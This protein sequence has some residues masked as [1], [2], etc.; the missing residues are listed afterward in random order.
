V[1]A[2]YSHVIEIENSLATALCKYFEQD[3]PANLRKGFFTIGAFDNIDHNPTSMTAKGALHGTA[4]SIFQ[5]PTLSNTG[6][7]REPIVIE[8]GGSHKFLLPDLYTCPRSFLTRL[9]NS[10]YQNTLTPLI[11][12]PVV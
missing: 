5:F 7:C 12:L 6:V 1:L 8:S 2:T 10:M 3:C 9:I 11:A 4:M